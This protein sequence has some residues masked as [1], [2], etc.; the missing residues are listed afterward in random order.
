M[1]VRRVLFRSELIG[2]LSHPARIP[3]IEVAVG[4]EVMVLLLRHLEPLDGHDKELLREFAAA[5]AVCWWLQPKGPDTAHPLNP[6]DLDT[7]AYALP[8]Y[9]V[10]MHYRPTDF[11]QVNPFINRALV[12]RALA[13]LDVRHDDRVADLFCGLGN[14]SQIGKELVRERRVQ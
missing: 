4:D 11:T 5:H 12:A 7:L 3:Q 10:R 6:D 9:G 13:F 1:E 8:Q 2:R 14:F